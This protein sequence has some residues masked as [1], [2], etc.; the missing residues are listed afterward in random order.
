MLMLIIKILFIEEVGEHIYAIDRMMWAL[1]KSSKLNKLAGVIV[2]G[3]TTINDTSVPFGKRIEAVILERFENLDIPICFNFPAGHIDD[4][5]AIIFGEEATLTVAK[6]GV[7]F[8][9]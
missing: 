4:N 7:V 3:I 6:S 2:G 8:E 1:Q 9:Q 5:R